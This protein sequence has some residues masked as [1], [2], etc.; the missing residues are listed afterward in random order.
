MHT[1]YKAGTAGNGTLIFSKSICP[2]L[3][4]FLNTAMVLPSNRLLRSSPPT[5]PEIVPIFE[6]LTEEELEE[7]LPLVLW[8]N[9]NEDNIKSFP[10]GWLGSWGEEEDE[11]LS[12]VLCVCMQAARRR[13][14]V[15][16]NL[17]R[18]VEALYAVV[19]HDSILDFL[20][21][22]GGRVERG[23]PIFPYA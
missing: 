1:V 9:F 22:Y 23:I 19:V 18:V 4:L 3:I 8:P 7:V 16:R 12:R 21:G 10:Q 17:L 20:H 14:L 6:R 15:R 2:M 5:V 13:Y 11:C